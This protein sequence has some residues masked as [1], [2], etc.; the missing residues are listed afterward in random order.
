MVADFFCGAGGFSEGFRQAGFEIAYAVDN[1]KRAIDT[2]RA[3][4]PDTKHILADVKE[5]CGNDFSDVDVVIGSP[6]CQQFSSANQNPNPKD[7]M[8]LVNHFL[9]L[10]DEIQPKYWIMEN[11]P[12][13]TRFLTED[14]LY[15]LPTK[16]ILNSADYGVPQT[17]RRLFAGKFFRPMPTHAKIANQNLQGKTLRPWK[18]WAEAIEYRAGDNI[19]L[20]QHTGESLYKKHKNRVGRLPYQPAPTATTAATHR[21]YRHVGENKEK[22]RILT[23][24]EMAILQGFP[25]HYELIGDRTTLIGNSVPPPLAKAIAQAILRKEVSG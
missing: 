12:E 6:P 18:G 13:L 11:V 7:G 5:I 17:R 2:H 8:E 19:E 4:H 22:I 16:C 1:W 14:M 23:I 9:R 3:N 21:I 10:V 15:Q 20:V 25:A 24:E